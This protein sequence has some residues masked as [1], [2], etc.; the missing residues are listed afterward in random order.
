[1]KQADIQNFK[2]C[3]YLWFFRAQPTIPDYMP[4][5]KF[6]QHFGLDFISKVDLFSTTAIY[7][8]YWLEKIQNK[9]L[10]FTTLAESVKNVF[11]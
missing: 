11:S 7:R 3:F 1:M 9:F 8:D 2:F 6:G 10:F 4:Y 5:Q